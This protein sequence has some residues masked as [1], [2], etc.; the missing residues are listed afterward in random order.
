[1]GALPGPHTTYPPGESIPVLKTALPE[2][3]APY[4]PEA[5]R[6]H[7]LFCGTLIL[8]ARAFVGPNVLA[9]VTQ[10]GVRRRAKQECQ[11]Q[12]PEERGHR[13]GRAGWAQQAGPWREGRSP[14]RESSP[15]LPRR[16]LPRG[17]GTQC[18]QIGLLFSQSWN[19][20]LK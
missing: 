5:H 7:T 10:T 14:P 13:A 8:Q 9:V 16:P 3:P 6:R 2:G 17:K 20:D 15:V 11:G 12:Q 18:H 4:L 1:M 19:L